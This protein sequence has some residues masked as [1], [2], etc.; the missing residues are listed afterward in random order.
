MGKT[1]KGSSW[2]VIGKGT[3]LVGLALSVVCAA[4]W[5]CQAQNARDPLP[6]GNNGIAA[7]YPADEGIER[8]P[9][10]IFVEKFD[11]GSLEAMLKRWEDVRGKGI[12]SFSSDV[13]EGSADPTSLLITHKGGQGTGAHLYRRLLPGYKRVFARFYVKFAP[14]CAPIHHLGT[15]LGGYNPPTRWP[16]GRAGIRPRGDERFTTGVE[17]FGKSWQWDFYT[18]W[19]GMHVH[20]DGR[21]WGT[22]FMAGVEK[23]KVERGKWICVEMMVKMN[24]PVNESNGEQ[25]FWIDGKLWRVDGQVVSH[26]GKGVPKGRW[27]GGWWHPDAASR[28]AFEGFKWRNVEDLAV[29]YVWTSLYITDAPDGHISKVWFDNIVIARDY[30]GPIRPRREST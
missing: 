23:R 15:N 6:E 25:A 2:R 24:E 28:R 20:G 11:E 1:R 9:S 14:D 12:M 29:N 10:V 27:T 26:I 13:H 7:R 19:Q 3:G 5:S 22:P 18:Y 21:Y 8:D 4:M 16:Q 30:I 17:P